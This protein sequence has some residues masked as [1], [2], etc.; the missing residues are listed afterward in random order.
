M[1]FFYPE[2]NIENEVQKLMKYA[3]RV[4]ERQMEESR[5]RLEDSR[6]AEEQQQQRELQEKLEKEEEERLRMKEHKL[7]AIK[8]A[9]ERERE[10]FI[11]KQMLQLKI[12]NCDE[13]RTHIQKKYHIEAKRCQLAQIEDKRK[14]RKAQLDEECI[15][16]EIHRK[17]YQ[18][19]L[20]RELNEKRKRKLM[21]EQILLDIKTQMKERSL[22]AEQEK[23]NLQ[24]TRCTSLP[25]PEHDKKLVQIKRSELAE[26]LKE[27][28]DTT[29]KLQ[30][31]RDEQEREVAKALNDAMQRELEREKA[32]RAAEKDILKKQIDQYYEYSKHIGKQRLT[33]EAKM[34]KLIDDFRQE[35]DKILVENRQKD[36]QKRLDL[37]NRVYEGQ[38][39]QMAE[40]EERRRIER[41]RELQGGMDEREVYEKHHL[42]NIDAKN[43]NQNSVKKY[44]EALKDQIKSAT[45]EKERLR[46]Q[47]QMQTN[48]LIEANVQELNFVQNYVK[49][50][51]EGHFKKHPNFAL[52]K[53]KV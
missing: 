6:L 7:L 15:W 23:I 9:K 25:F 26:K 14:L 29:R 33:E 27:Q 11:K 17:N 46:S 21:E 50:S 12:N 53:N 28:M 35:Y 19:L 38:R 3:D 44:R 13:I 8:Q 45:L 49:G 52:M 42:E 39:Q 2:I 16:N 30:T 48:K 34:D 10:E 40:V 4:Y 47:N 37:A 31:Q 18:L 51:F 41:E 32:A 24:E 22:K 20:D 43:R 36:L 1:N 5:K